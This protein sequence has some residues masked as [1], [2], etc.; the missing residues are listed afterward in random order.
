MPE[1]NYDYSGIGKAEALLLYS[2]LAS[3]SV[4]LTTG[5][6]GDIVFKLLW[7]MCTWLANKE[8]LILNIAATDLQT[9]SQKGSF[10]GSFDDAFTA[11]HGHPEL[12]T[13]EQK[14]AIDA[15]VMAAFRKFGVFGQLRD[16]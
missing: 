7:R 4:W 13:P 9:L 6:V 1:A 8:V 15:P 2:A 14:A 3:Q 10:D 12:L 11:I 5:L 16:D